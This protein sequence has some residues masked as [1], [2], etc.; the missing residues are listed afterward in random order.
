[1]VLM[2]TCKSGFFNAF[3]HLKINDQL[4]EIVRKSYDDAINAENV[5]LNR[6]ESKRLLSQILRLALED[7]NK[8]LDDGSIQSLIFCIFWAQISFVFPKE[9][10]DLSVY[11]L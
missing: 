3:S 4:I 10:D 6:T 2:S 8:K 9:M 11:S 7:L 1:M 5:E